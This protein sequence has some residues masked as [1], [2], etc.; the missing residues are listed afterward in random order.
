M[1]VTTGSRDSDGASSHDLRWSCNTSSRRGKWGLGWGWNSYSRH[2]ESFRRKK[3]GATSIRDGNASASNSNCSTTRRRGGGAGDLSHAQAV[4]GELRARV[5]A[6]G[7]RLARAPPLAGGR[8][9]AGGSRS[10][11]TECSQRRK[12]QSGR[13]RRRA[14]RRGTSRAGTTALA[15]L[16][17]AGYVVTLHKDHWIASD[18]PAATGRLRP[19]RHAAGAD[20]WPSRRARARLRLGSG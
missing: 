10:T 9:G 18:A 11:R 14:R 2:S 17:R 1:L 12:A 16:W 3:D 5:W 8:V 7:A 13:L 15:G 20:P 4:L 6:A 19:R